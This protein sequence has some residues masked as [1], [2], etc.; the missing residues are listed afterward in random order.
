VAE[1]FE[2]VLVGF[3]P[4]LSEYFL[5]Y[6]KKNDN[7]WDGVRGR[8]ILDYGGRDRYMTGM[9]AAPGCMGLKT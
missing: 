6:K 2:A 8:N 7:G 3:W 9:G 4:D 5:I 1:R